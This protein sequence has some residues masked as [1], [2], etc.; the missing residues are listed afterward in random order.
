MMNRLSTAA[1]STDVVAAG[2]SRRR[3]TIT[4]RHGG[5]SVSLS[6]VFARHSRLQHRPVVRADRTPST[7]DL[8]LHPTL[9]RT[10]AIHQSYVVPLRAETTSMSN[11][12]WHNMTWLI[13]RTAQNSFNWF[14]NLLLKSIARFV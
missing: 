2:G 8:D 5:L 4:H 14:G 12:F 10:P 7:V 6:R 13:S 3:C 9:L 11:V 1:M